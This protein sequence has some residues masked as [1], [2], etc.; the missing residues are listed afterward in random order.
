MVESVSWRE[1]RVEA[2]PREEEASLRR[3][4]L[5]MVSGV[6]VMLVA[7]FYRDVGDSPLSPSKEKER[8]EEEARVE[9]RVL[10]PGE[11]ESRQLAGKKSGCVRQCFPRR[12]LSLLRV[13][14]V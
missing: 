5:A 11:I 8:E 14:A 7:R 4:G 3:R 1:D 13:G 12:C 10:L 9:R 6:L 2:G